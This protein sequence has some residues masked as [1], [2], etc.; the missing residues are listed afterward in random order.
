MNGDGDIEITT[1][2]N[3]TFSSAVFWKD[4][5]AHSLT[6]SNAFLGAPT[7]SR[8]E[9]AEIAITGSYIFLLCRRKC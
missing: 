7:D 5:S 6:K 1:S 8:K 2:G 9:W 4:V 3:N